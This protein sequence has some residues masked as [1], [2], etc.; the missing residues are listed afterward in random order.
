LGV[1]RTDSQ[2]GVFFFSPLLLL[3]V[4]FAVVCAL[5]CALQEG[6]RRG[7]QSPD[8]PVS[9]ARIFFFFFYCFCFETLVV[10][11]RCDRLQG[12]CKML[13]G[14]KPNVCGGL[15]SIGD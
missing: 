9:L 15:G 5:A 11:C 14:A 2:V 4:V 7:F 8:C 12:L 1:E 10:S 13:C 3:H 6:I